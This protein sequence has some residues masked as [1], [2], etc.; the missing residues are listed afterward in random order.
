MTV[1]Q[2]IHHFTRST[3][4][5]KIA[6]YVCLHEGG[7][8]GILTIRN[9]IGA[10][11]SSP[12]YELGFPTQRLFQKNYDCVPNDPPLHQEHIAI[13]ISEYVYLHEEGI[14]LTLMFHHRPAIRGLELSNIVQ[15]L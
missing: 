3:Y 14:Q 2:M 5:I 7:Y 12:S 11:D 9:T 8:Q 13:K 10:D 4:S 1:S 15:D 6:E